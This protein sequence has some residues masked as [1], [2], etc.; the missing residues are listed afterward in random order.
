MLTL[1]AV[2]HG[3]LYALI[4]GVGEESGAERCHKIACRVLTRCQ[5]GGILL[6]L[7]QCQDAERRERNGN[8]AESHGAE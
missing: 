8:G 6:L 3:M 1:R 7:T 5:S 2:P 4:S